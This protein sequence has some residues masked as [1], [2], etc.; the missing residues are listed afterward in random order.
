MTFIGYKLALSVGAPTE[1]VI[2][3]YFDC[4][5]DSVLLSEPRVHEAIN[6]INPVPP[7]LP[8]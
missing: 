7:V 6:Q 5:L 4:V 1:L 2:V 3:I 8:P